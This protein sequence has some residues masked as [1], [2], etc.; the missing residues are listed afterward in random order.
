LALRI[1]ISVPKFYHF[2]LKGKLRGGHEFRL[3]A[4]LNIVTL[5]FSHMF[6]DIG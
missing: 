4:K 6:I 2:F 5:F 3:A 1:D